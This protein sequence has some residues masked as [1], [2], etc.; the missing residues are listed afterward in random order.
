MGACV[1]LTDHQKL[2]LKAL[3]RNG[4]MLF[5]DRRWELVERWL[6][7]LWETS[8]TARG[9]QWTEVAHI[10]RGSWLTASEGIE[11]S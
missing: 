4:A 10:V 9:I 2:F 11:K 3:G 7:P 8:A 6:R 5:P 1:Q